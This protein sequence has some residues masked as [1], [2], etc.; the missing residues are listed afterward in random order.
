MTATCVVDPTKFDAKKASEALAE[1]GFEDS[2]L[3]KA[4]PKKGD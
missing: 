2:T 3:I 1:A 4:E